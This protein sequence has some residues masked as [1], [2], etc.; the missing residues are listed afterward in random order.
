MKRMPA[1]LVSP[2]V[3]FFAHESCTVTAE[4]LDVGG[5]AVRRLYWG[6]TSGI[7]DAALTPEMIAER[8]PEIV[9]G[10]SDDRVGLIPRGVVK[11]K[12]YKPA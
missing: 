7:T 1:E 6:M 9:K 5:G 11:H 2:A 8:W 12:P 10:T 3:A 4:C